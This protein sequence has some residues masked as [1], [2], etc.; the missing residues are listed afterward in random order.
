MEEKEKIKNF[1]DLI[2]WQKAHKLTLLIYRETK[3]FPTSEQFGLMSQMRRAAVSVGSNI[4]E[5][6]GRG[7]AK[8]KTQFYLIALG[9]LYELQSQ[10]LV[11]RDLEYIKDI[12]NA[13]ALSKETARLLAGLIKSSPSR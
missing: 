10:L 5:G 3:N 4:A 8:E 6:F 7:S 9:S 11:A 13:A 1:Y 12:A 2:A